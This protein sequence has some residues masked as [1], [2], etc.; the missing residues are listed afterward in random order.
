MAEEHSV[1]ELLIL[2]KFYQRINKEKFLNKYSSS[3]YSRLNGYFTTPVLIA[4]GISSFLSL[5]SSSDIFDKD[6][7]QYCSITVGFIVGCSTVINS[8]SSS[9]SY[10]AKKDSFSVAA[11]SYD[12]LLTKIEFEI[13]NPN[14]EF[15]SFC[16]DLETSILEIKSN[17][18]YFPPEV[19][20]KLYKKNKHELDDTPNNPPTSSPARSNRS[21]NDLTSL[22]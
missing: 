14:E 19:I 6:E 8:I 12:K 7:K 18:K 10:S 20:H 2:Q 1:K 17:C 16:D 3:Y 15:N 11:D 21:T 4:T 22:V 13:L 5:L 9:Y